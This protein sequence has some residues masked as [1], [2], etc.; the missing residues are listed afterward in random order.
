MN[1]ERVGD[2]TRIIETLE[3]LYPERPLYP[4]DEQDRRRALELEEFFDEELGPHIRRALF[5]EVTRDRVSFAQTAA[6]RAGRGAQLFYKTTAPAAAPVLR[7][8]FGITPK[9]AERGRQKTL[10]ALDRVF[11]GA[12][13]ERLPRG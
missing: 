7:R 8:R 2:S 3:Q 6:P 13:A 12:A 10:A 4:A 11:V 9:T 1:G 5:A